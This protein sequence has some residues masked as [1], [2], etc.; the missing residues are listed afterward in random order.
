MK[1]LILVITIL[2]LTGCV[3]G[4][5]NVACK[6]YKI[7]VSNIGGIA[8]QVVDGKINFYSDTSMTTDV[9]TVMPN[10]KWRKINSADENNPSG[11]VLGSYAN[12]NANATGIKFISSLTMNGNSTFTYYIIVWVNEINQGQSD[13]STSDLQKHFYGEVSIESSNGTGVTGVFQT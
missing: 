10:L 13:Y 6:V 12:N 8:T 1:K 3:D 11:S 5:K 2:L 9:N 7:D 4:N